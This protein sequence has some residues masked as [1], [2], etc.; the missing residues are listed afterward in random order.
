MLSTRVSFSLFVFSRTQR[1]S[2]I[3]QISA[4]Q[5]YTMWKIIKNKNGRALETKNFVPGR[6]LY[7]KIN[8]D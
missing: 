1:R 4:L 7:E 3:F 8:L 5:N 6:G 2:T